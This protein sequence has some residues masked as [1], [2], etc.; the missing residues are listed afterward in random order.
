MEDVLQM[1]GVYTIC[2]DV[3]EMETFTDP[4]ARAAGK[5]EITRQSHIQ[6]E[7]QSRVNRR[8][9]IEKG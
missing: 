4:S 8:Q 5:D 9:S 2:G 1:N 6:V 7:G 3:F